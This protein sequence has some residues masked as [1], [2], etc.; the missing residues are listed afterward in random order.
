M[1]GFEFD[2]MVHLI[3]GQ[4]LPAVLAIKSIPAKRHV[5]VATTDS[6]GLAERL[7]TLYAKDGMAFDI[8]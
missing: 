6:M 8:V 1:S 7:K 2:V 4:G 3:G 5:L